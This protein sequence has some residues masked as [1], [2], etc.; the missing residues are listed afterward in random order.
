MADRRIDHN[1]NGSVAVGRHHQVRAATPVDKAIFV[2]TTVVGF[3]VVSP[4]K[5]GW[6]A[7]SFQLALPWLVTCIVGRF[8]RRFSLELIRLRGFNAN[9]PS[10][11]AAF[12]FFDFLVLYRFTYEDEIG[13]ARVAWLSSA[14][15]LALFLASIGADATMRTERNWLAM[16]VLSVLA[17]YHGY[18]TVRA[19]NVLL[20]HSP[21]SVERSMVISKSSPRSSVLNL[22]LTLK[23]WGPVNDIR[24]VPIS[25]GVYRA[26]KPGEPV[27]LVL[28]QGA[29]GIPWYTAQVCPWNGA[30][31]RF[32]AL[33]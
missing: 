20:D 13:W 18:V 9:A 33:Q 17:L 5:L 26:A 3:L 22:N 19:L 10:S 16:A 12:Y 2:L 25:K 21:A 28:Y 6:L 15:G 4:L 7:V 24:T 11:L 8:P 31:V 27:C 32:G 29:L 1:P 14:V 23:P 30:P